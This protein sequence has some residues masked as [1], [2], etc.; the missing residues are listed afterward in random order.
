MFP[1]LLDQDVEFHVHS[2]YFALIVLLPVLLVFHRCGELSFELCIVLAAFLCFQ[3]CA[4]SSFL[5][6]FHSVKSCV[7]SSFLDVF[8][9]VQSFVPSSSLAIFLSCQSYVPSSFL[10][11]LRSVQSCVPSSFLAVFLSFQSYVPSSF[12]AVF[13]KTDYSAAAAT[14]GCSRELRFIT[15]L[16]GVRW[17]IAYTDGNWKGVL[18]SAYHFMVQVESMYTQIIFRVEEKC[19]TCIK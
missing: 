19:W 14:S 3:G 17:W 5:A 7:P 6:V 1:C 10:A 18:S 2:L 9:W 13:Q 4:H 11:V 8:L 15:R 16:I 12:L